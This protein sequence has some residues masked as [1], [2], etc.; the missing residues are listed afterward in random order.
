MTA[1]ARLYTLPEA[2]E[3]RQSLVIGEHEARMVIG[4]Q[5]AERWIAVPGTAC[6]MC[7][8]PLNASVSY[9]LVIMPNDPDLG[10]GLSAGVCSA[11]GMLPRQQ[12]QGDG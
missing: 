6:I 8:N 4:V 9:V 3:A 1:L 11:C 5:N 7:G 12:L 10:L 2:L